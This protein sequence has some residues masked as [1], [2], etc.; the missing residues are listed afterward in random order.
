MHTIWSG[1]I[2]FGLVYIPV[3][4]AAAI[5]RRKKIEFHFI[6]KK[7][8]SR[9]EYQKHCPK[10]DL[11]VSDS[12]IA[13]GYEFKPK[14]YVLLSDED[15]DNAKLQA[16]NTLEIKFFT[17]E[18]QI[19]CLY[20]DHPY[21]LIPAAQGAKAYFLLARALE[22]TAKVGVAKFIMRDREYAAVLKVR[23]NHLMLHTLNYASEFVSPKKVKLPAKSKVAKPE[24]KIAKELISQLTKHFDITEFKD[25][26]QQRLRNLIAKKAKGEKL[27]IEKT[28]A[29]VP[30]KNIMQAL[31]ESVAQ[32]SS[33]R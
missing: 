9:I 15:F 12:E 13:K 17:D 10:C 14:K 16:E 30:H 27:I 32:S 28:P 3:K 33:Q 31:K 21:Y 24:L 18:S 8:N 29:P 1:A 2:T 20:Y 26:Y 23:N 4:L 6:H 22:D 25:E 11:D 19:D 5:S 7:C